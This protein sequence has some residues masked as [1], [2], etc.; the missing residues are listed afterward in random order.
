MDN[1]RTWKRLFLVALLL[2]AVWEGVQCGLLFE[3]NG[4]WA[5]NLGWMIFAV[6][7]DGILV[8]CIVWGA[9]RFADMSGVMPQSARGW[10]AMLL[11]GL[12]AGLVV[13]WLAHSL[14]WWNY[15]PLMPTIEVFGA[16]VGLSPL[17]QMSLL[18]ALCAFIA[19]RTG[20]RN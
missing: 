12:I 3:M 15:G 13:E 10:G 9:S 11:L 18:P 17:A 16:T 5:A 4:G 19:G 8:L 7:G 2:N 20:R 1:S 14:D 6:I